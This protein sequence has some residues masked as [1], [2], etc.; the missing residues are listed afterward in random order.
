VIPFYQEGKG[1]TA[2]HEAIAPVLNALT[3]VHFEIICVDD[4]SRDD[5]AARLAALARSDSRYVVLELSRNFGKEAALTAGLDQAR[6]DAIIVL[7][8][9]LQDPP[10]LIP[11]MLRHWQHG[12]EVVLARRADRSCD[13]WLKRTTAHW[14]YRLHNAMADIEMPADVGDC[15]LMDRQV[16]DTLRSLP[17]RQRFMKGLFCW[18]GFRTEI[19]DY[20]RKPRAFGETKFAGWKLWNLAIEGITSFSTAPLR[21][22]TYVGLIGASI[23]TAYAGFILAA[24]LFWGIDVPGYASILISV[25]LFGSMQ[26]ISLGL[27]GEYIGRIYIE[28]KQRPVYIV[29]RRQSAE[30]RTVTMTTPARTSAAH[31]RTLHVGTWRNT[32]AGSTN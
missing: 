1:V 7:D 4:G 29:R 11:R 5:T 20:E 19:I 14:F 12:A 8:A 31:H 13:G 27:I 9:D 18:V 16:V 22:W 28:S 10:E 3:Q 32:R 21:I 23:T 6:G 15:R 24:A 26:L 17:E 2:F 30:R 25:L